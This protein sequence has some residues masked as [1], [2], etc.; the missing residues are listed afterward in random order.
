MKSIFAHAFIIILNIFFIVFFQ[1][2]KLAACQLWRL[3]KGLLDVHRGFDLESPVKVFSSP[4]S[5]DWH[6]AREDPKDDSWESKGKWEASEKI[7]II[8]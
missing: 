6:L 4:V 5:L 2:R 3:R 7:G 8:E 1:F